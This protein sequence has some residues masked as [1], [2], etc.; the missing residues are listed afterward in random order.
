MIRFDGY[1]ATTNAANHYQIAELFGS[2]LA[3]DQGRGFHQFGHRLRFKD[4]CGEV[5]AVQWG[6]AHG[7]R[8]MLEVKGERS[9]EV[10]ERLRSRFPHR[11]TRMDS[12]A[13]F[14]AP[15]AFQRLYRECVAIKRMHRIKGR[16]EGDWD[17]FPEEG[18][19]FYMGSPQSVAMTRLYEKGRQPE[20][21]HLGRDN[22]VRLEVQVRPA[23]EAKEAFAN[24]SPADA[25]GGAKWT[26]ELAARVLSDHVDPHPAGSTWRKSERDRA[27]AFMCRQY[28]AH[29]LSLKD[30]VGDWQSVGLTLAEIIQEAST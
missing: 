5:G 28:G 10:V 4:D 24:V 9:P 25:W 7:D 13:D 3:V 17:D 6:G 21:R 15:R 20:Y 19:T 16:K 23:K 22:W 29:L 1:T 8:V 30:D 18:R 12:C 11:V 27:L 14:D 26:R 2:D